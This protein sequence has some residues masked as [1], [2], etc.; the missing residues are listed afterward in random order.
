MSFGGTGMRDWLIQRIT[1]T[2]LALYLIVLVGVCL[3]LPNLDH[4]HWHNLFAEPIVRVST[5]MALVSI[6][7]HAWIGMWTI[8]TDYIKP[9]GLR[10][11]F[12]SVIIFLL[13]G[14]LFWGLQ[15]LWGI[16][17]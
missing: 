5:F 16:A 15:I 13:V 8:A 14:E 11:V 2:Y 6:A 3:C 17:V 12:L 4:T 7:L 10:L 9:Y 1:A